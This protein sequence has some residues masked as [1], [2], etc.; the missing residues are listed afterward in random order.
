MRR[1]ESYPDLH[2]GRHRRVR[3]GSF[4]TPLVSLGRAL[5]LNPTSVPRACSFDARSIATGGAH[6]RSNRVALV[7]ERDRPTPGPAPRV[8]VERAS[9][10]ANARRK[11][12][13]PTLAARA[14]CGRSADVHH[15]G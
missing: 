4:E 10:R 14:T 13:T 11:G 6:R 9:T 2:P 12:L 3:E 5:E 7:I 1:Y 8:R 15:V